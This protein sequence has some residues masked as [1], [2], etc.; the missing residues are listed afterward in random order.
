MPEL[1]FPATPFI[2]KEL[3]HPSSACSE[4]G[5]Q[6]ASYAGANKSS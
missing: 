4:K 3:L 6:S 5:R 1:S 2:L